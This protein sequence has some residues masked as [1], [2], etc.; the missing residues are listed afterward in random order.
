MQRGFHRGGTEFAE[1]EDFDKNSFLG[2]LGVSAVRYSGL[3]VSGRVKRS[4]RRN[5]FDYCVC[6]RIECG[7]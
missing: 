3:Y 7:I 4:E 5:D 1:S 2:A 6:D